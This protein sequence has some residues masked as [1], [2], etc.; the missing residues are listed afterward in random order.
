MMFIKRY[1]NELK[2]KMCRKITHNTVQLAGGG[3]LRFAVGLVYSH[4]SG[5]VIGRYAQHAVTSE[6][7][8]VECGGEYV[9][10]VIP[11]GNICRINSCSKM[12]Y[13]AKNNTI[14]DNEGTILAWYKGDAV[15]ASAAFL[16]L[17]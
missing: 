4:E 12:T 8:T 6:K 14:K 9:G 5:E 15:G 10:T 11:D 3:E 7:Y 13:T 17:K 2:N 1:I 16:C